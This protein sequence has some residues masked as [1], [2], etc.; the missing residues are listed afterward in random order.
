M[1][2]TLRAVSAL[3]NRPLVDIHQAFWLPK[4]KTEFFNK[5]K[6]FYLNN[7]NANICDV[8]LSIKT[9]FLLLRIMMCGNDI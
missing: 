5:I 6:N 9:V 1:S 2:V 8:L 7:G 4:V 3:V